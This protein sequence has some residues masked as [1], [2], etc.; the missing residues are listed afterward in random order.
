MAD[1]RASA[2]S[3]SDSDSDDN[4][5][6]S[7]LRAGAV[8]RE[9]VKQEPGAEVKTEVKREAKP[10]IKAEVKEVKAGD[11]DS[12]DDIPIV[13]LAK[14]KKLKVE[15]KAVKAEP[16]APAGSATTPRASTPRKAK[17]RIK[18]L[19]D[20]LRSLEDTKCLPR[21]ATFAPDQVQAAGMH[22]GA[23][24]LAQRS[25]HP[26]AAVPLVVCSRVASQEGGRPGTQRNTM[27]SIGAK[28]ISGLTAFIGNGTQK[29]HGVQELDGYPGAYIR[30][31]VC[32]GTSADLVG[33]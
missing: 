1:A 8:K 31:R 3:D 6:L 16:A 11:S 21:L 15:A 13:G 20:L 26:G 25:A 2:S 32:S 23:L 14:R 10:E 19:A 30:V 28:V 18:V 29:L 7:K 17:K 27:R 22:R 12:D 4:V 5:P 9:P 24:Q 33:D